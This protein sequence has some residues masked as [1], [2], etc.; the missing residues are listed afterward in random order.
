MLIS[1]KISQISSTVEVNLN[2]WSLTCKEYQLFVKPQ[3]F[4]QDIDILTPRK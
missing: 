2:I 1:A 4:R 3:T